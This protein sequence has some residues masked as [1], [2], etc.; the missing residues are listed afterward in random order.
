MKHNFALP[1]KDDAA[2]SITFQLKDMSF[3]SRKV[4]RILRPQMDRF[5]S[6][7][8]HRYSPISYEHDTTRRARRLT[9]VA[10]FNEEPSLFKFFLSAIILAW[11]RRGPICL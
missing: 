9:E 3:P 5:S 10:V 6:V 1:D 4:E 7:M 11:K 8:V 2:G